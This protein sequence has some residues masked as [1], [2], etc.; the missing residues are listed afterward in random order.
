MAKSKKA[1]QSGVAKDFE[2]SD[3]LSTHRPHLAA[4][5]QNRPDQDLIEADFGLERNLS[6]GPQCGFQ[7]GK[8]TA[9]IRPVIYSSSK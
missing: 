5:E 3:V 1:P 8:G 7:A 9:Q 4:V 2:P 6:S